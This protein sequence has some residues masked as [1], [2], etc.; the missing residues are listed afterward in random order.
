MDER[1]GDFVNLLDALDKGSGL[2]EVEEDEEGDADEDHCDGEAP[3]CDGDVELCDA[4]D[5]LLILVLLV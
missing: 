2:D 1:V 4:E 3:V 5:G